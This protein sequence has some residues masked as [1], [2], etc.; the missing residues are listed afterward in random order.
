MA[1]F[2]DA[3]IDEMAASTRTFAPMRFGEVG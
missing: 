1:D 2:P 3:E